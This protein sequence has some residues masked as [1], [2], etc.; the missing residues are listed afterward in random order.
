MMRGSELPDNGLGEA[1]LFNVE[2]QASRFTEIASSQFTNRL[3]LKFRLS[4]L[5]LRLQ[6]S[7]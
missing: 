2:T 7:V 1:G 4:S 6:L 3:A 5:D